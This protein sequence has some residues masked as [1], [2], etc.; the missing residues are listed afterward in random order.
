MHFLSITSNCYTTPRLMCNLYAQFNTFLLQLHFFFLIK[1]IYNA[2]ELLHNKHDKLQM[3]AICNKC[4]YY[5]LVHET[6]G[7]HISEV[8]HRIICFIDFQS[9]YEPFPHRFLKSL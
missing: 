6:I 7:L 9:V 3:Y 8:P 4:L 1:L 2:D 5:F